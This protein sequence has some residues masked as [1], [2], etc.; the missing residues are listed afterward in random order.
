MFQ[1]VNDELFFN[2]VELHLHKTLSPSLAGRL[3]GLV[4]PTFADFL[5]AIRN[6]EIGSCVAR[7]IYSGSPVPRLTVYSR[8]LKCWE[9]FV[10]D[11]IRLIR[12]SGNVVRLFDLHMV[13]YV[14]DDLTGIL[15][16]G[17][18]EVV[19]LNP[20]TVEAL[21]SV[22]DVDGLLSALRG[23]VDVGFIS[24]TFG[25]YRGFRVSDLDLH[26]VVEELIS[27]YFREFKKTL[28]VL[29]VS[30]RGLECVGYMERFGRL[31]HSLR[32]VLREGGDLASVLTSL[33]PRQREVLVK[34]SSDIHALELLL[35][36]LPIVSCHSL[37]RSVPPSAETLLHYLLVKDWELLTL[38]QVIYLIASGYPVEVIRDEV[39]RCVRLYESL[40]K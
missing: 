38:S 23:C 14:L 35:A 30:T 37:L 10:R 27:S 26:R 34:S 7:E 2:H 36:T 9:E 12:P 1:T 31:R 25:K 39:G 21:K 24:K 19:Y 20:Q 28:E 4:T 33:T 6:L 15:S 22:G 3:S 32:R 17:V 13:R 5:A 11:E 8:L 16:A 40:P 18:E 29:G